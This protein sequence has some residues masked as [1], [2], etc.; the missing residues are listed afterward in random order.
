MMDRTANSRT[1]RVLRMIGEGLCIKEIA[2]LLSVSCKTVEY[3]WGQCKRVYGFR[4]YQD[5][6]HFCLSSRMIRNEF[7]PGD[8]TR[9]AVN[10]AF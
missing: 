5:A 3:H 1:M 7:D 10:Q 6:T 4:C 8:E 2:S 9:E